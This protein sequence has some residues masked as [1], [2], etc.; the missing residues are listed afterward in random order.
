MILMACPR[1]FPNTNLTSAV[2]NMMAMWLV[3]VPHKPFCGL[4][5]GCCGWRSYAVVALSKVLFLHYYSLVFLGKQTCTHTPLCRVLLPWYVQHLVWISISKLKFYS[6]SANESTYLHC[7]SKFAS[8]YSQK[9][10]LVS[11]LQNTFV[12][13]IKCRDFWDMISGLYSQLLHNVWHFCNVCTT[14]HAHR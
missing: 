4:Q 10:W 12:C 3:E 8:E 11:W 13:S 1:T 14:F 5:S 6:R 2:G 7:C 9:I